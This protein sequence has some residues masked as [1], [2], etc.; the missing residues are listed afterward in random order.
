MNRKVN[1]KYRWIEMA[2]LVWTLVTVL[3]M[4]VLAAEPSTY[5]CFQLNVESS[6]KV[7]IATTS[8]GWSVKA[9]GTDGSCG[10]TD[11]QT[12]KF[13]ISNTDTTR[14]VSFDISVTSS[15]ASPS[16]APSGSQTLAA[17]GSL[18]QFTATSGAGSRAYTTID[19]SITNI[20]QESLGANVT[21]TI[22]PGIGGTIKVDGTEV[23]DQ[24]DFTK[25]DTET[26]TLTATADS[27]YIFYGW[28]SSNGVLT[29]DGITSYT[30]AGK[31]AATL[32]PL[33]IK[34][35]SAIYSIVGSNP[36]LYYGYL[37]EAITAASS[38]GTITIHRSGTAYHSDG[39]TQEFEI[40]AE[41]TLL[42]PYDNEN[43]VVTNGNDVLDT[44]NA[45]VTARSQY[46]SLTLASNTTITVNG[47]ISI[48]SGRANQFIG[49]VGP[50]GAIYMEY[51][52]KITVKSGGILY[53]W[54]YIF[55]GTSGSGTVTVESGGIVYEPFSVMDY[56]GS[57]SAT[58][59]IKDNNVFPLR[60]YSIRNVE[61]EMILNSGAIEYGFACLYGSNS[62]VGTN[63]VY[64]PLIA[65]ASVNNKTPMLQNYGTITKSYVDGRMRV[66][67]GGNIS[68]NPLSVKLAKS[69]GTYTL[70][71]SETY[72]I[73]FPSCWDITIDSGTVTLN[74]NVIMCEGSNLTISKNTVLDTNG[75][76]L[77]VLD[78]DN[79][80]GAVG[81]V[82][83]FGA[84]GIGGGLNGCSV[85]IAD[86]HGAYYT[87]V[88]KDAV[89]NI[90]G[91]LIASGG[92]YTSEVGACIT[93]SEGG[94]QVDVTITSA[95][96]TIS[97][98][99]TNSASTVNVNPA[100]LL[101]SSGD[102]VET[103]AG[104][105]NT[106]IY[107]EG[108]WICKTHTGV[109]TDH[110]CDVC[111]YVTECKDSDHDLK[112]DI[113]GLD[114][115]FDIYATSISVTDSLNM[116]FYIKADDLV[117]GIVTDKTVGQGY[118]AV[119]NRAYTGNDTE[120]KKE[121]KISSEDWSV[122][123]H[124]D[125]QCVRFCYDNISAKEMTDAISVVI[126]NSND[127]QVS[128]SYTETVKDYAIR[129]LNCY[130]G[131]S[132]ASMRKALVDML[133]YGAACQ[134][135]FNYNNEP[136]KLANYQLDSK[137]A[138]EATQQDPVCTSYLEDTVN[139]VAASI[140][141]RNRLMYTFYFKNISSDMKAIVTD[142]T[143]NQL[144]E[145]T[146]MATDSTPGF[147]Q[148]GNWLGVD[149]TG[150][151]MVD[152]RRM[153]TCKVYNGNTLVASGT[154]SVEGYVKRAK[155]A[156]LNQPVFGMLMRFVDSAIAYSN[157]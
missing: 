80:P 71:S 46:R 3:A 116:Y 68:L 126:Y 72:G 125:V 83:E 117:D 120:K 70:S 34:S 93:S 42:I 69:L 95:D 99:A 77:Y 18:T 150:L 25:L 79:D 58:T 88:P 47:A 13:T 17:S 131:E 144:L 115:L 40:P 36:V 59:T 2:I 1:K 45:S 11:T 61:V 56:P 149:V 92:F 21:T 138:G 97:V 105:S 22:K 78:A 44:Y 85:N 32:W 146:G 98:K 54:G 123:P 53:A 7:E 148:Y 24:T 35:D 15:D 62:L 81:N 112:C 155:D 37:D 136:E 29:T 157:S 121:I 152:G 128:Q 108:R 139:M 26:Y 28:M 142:D 153:L 20:V 31:N 130:E 156:G 111:G 48:G 135:Y 49:Q 94:G 43:T 16:G 57:S 104:G 134:D 137:F 82:N 30:Y 73:Y 74:D 133:N 64:I 27:G 23:T 9:Y 84:A 110:T 86:V 103:A 6:G 38:N 118:Y 4:I 113:C 41:V 132:N 127:V 66:S 52:S 154:D 65:N 90:N 51:D 33:F 143:G 109:T 102:F 147:I 101:N 75:N 96:T 87:Y 67:I 50:Y 60:S 14:G 63:P 114:Y 76:N 124:G 145:I 55:H 122:E 140:S 106:Y 19:I 89:I 12:V 107:V 129:T 5:N 151:S 10:A 8:N 39:T 91:T 119:I 100:K 141:A